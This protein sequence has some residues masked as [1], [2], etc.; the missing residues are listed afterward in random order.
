MHKLITFKALLLLAF[1]FN[2]CSGAVMADEAV[3]SDNTAETINVQPVPEEKPLTGEVNATE[4]KPVSE[5]LSNEKFKSAVNNLESAQVDVREQLSVC[6]TKVDEKTIEVSTKKA[7][8]STLKK[9]YRMLQKKM[10]NIDKMK[11]MLNSNID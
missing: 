5:S 9:E 11:R 3:F 10:K 2:Y 4:T 7:E 6:K 8:L 1:V